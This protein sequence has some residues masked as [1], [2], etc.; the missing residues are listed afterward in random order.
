MIKC[1]KFEF[2][3]TEQE[4]EKA[5]DGNVRSSKN[6]KCD[7][8][9]SSHE[10]ENNYILLNEETASG[11]SSSGRVVKEEGK[12]K[13]K[14]GLQILTRSQ[15]CRLTG[16]NTQPCTLLGSRKTPSQNVENSF[17]SPSGSLQSKKGAAQ[18]GS[19]QMT[20][21]SM[22]QNHQT[23]GKVMKFRLLWM[24]CTRKRRIWKN[25]K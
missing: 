8:E 10:L 16:P 7:G 13:K 25:Q 20:I 12:Q 17:I 1:L 11:S 23:R 14:L 3:V 22:L 15:N 21:S 2:C 18:N 9:S 5:V 6:A 24:V 4:K 19:K